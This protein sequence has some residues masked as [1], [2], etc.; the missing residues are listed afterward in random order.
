M[1]I[2]IS[3]KSL[4]AWT[5]IAPLFI[6]FVPLYVICFLCAAVI[7]W[8]EVLQTFYAAYCEWCYRLFK[9]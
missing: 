4:G 7:Y 9:R 6:L 3:L 5:L 1:R 2:R 8:V